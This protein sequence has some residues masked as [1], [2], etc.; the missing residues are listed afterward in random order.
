M[1][2]LCCSVLCSISARFPGTDLPFLCVF[3]LF[4]VPA[5]S[6]VCFRAWLGMDAFP[7]L[8]LWL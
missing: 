7:Q 5:Y 1:F 8:F 4:P 6:H 3:F 2:L